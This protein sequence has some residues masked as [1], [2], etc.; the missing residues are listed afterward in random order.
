MFQS[1]YWIL[2]DFRFSYNLPGKSHLT[3]ERQ[4][5]IKESSSNKNIVKFVLQYTNISTY[6][7]I[8]FI[9]IA[10]DQIQKNFCF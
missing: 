10:I 5:Y 4:E 6:I 9:F 3:P 1:V 7:F 2:L 8:E